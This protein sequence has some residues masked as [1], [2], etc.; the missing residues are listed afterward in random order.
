MAQKRA[1][2]NEDFLGELLA[3]GTRKNPE[4]PQ[5]VE[6]AY[7]RRKLLRALAGERARR[8]ISQTQVA[9]KM[10]TSQSAVARLEAGEIDAKISTV[11]RFA[12][13]LGKRVEW[14]L[15]AGGTARKVAARAR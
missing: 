12:A 5:L 10:K 3:E 4:F 6:A 13:A 1:K 2:S 8:G 9:A 11:D 15:V 7:R 14:R